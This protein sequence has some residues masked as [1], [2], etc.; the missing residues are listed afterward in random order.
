MSDDLNEKELVAPTE[1]RF[2]KTVLIAGI[3]W[4]IFGGWGLL[5]GGLMIAAGGPFQSPVSFWSVVFGGACVYVGIHT[6]RGTARGMWGNAIG[7][8]FFAT[9][10]LIRAFSI[11]AS[12]HPR[13]RPEY[14]IAGVLD[15]AATAFAGLGFL[16]A[17]I[18]AFWG[19]H[20]YRFWLQ[21]RKS[22]SL[23]ST[24]NDSST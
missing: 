22:G 3:L 24:P 5:L 2:P 17:G 6:V 23:V 13:Q 21:A 14:V 12:L 18:L 7:S 11:V 10:A 15:A 4:I 19:R 1:P 8:I 20:E 16:A 9:F